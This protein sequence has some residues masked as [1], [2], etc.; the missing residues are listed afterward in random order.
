MKLHT[1]RYRDT[2]E[3]IVKPYQGKQMSQSS[4]WNAA[5]DGKNINMMKQ[6]LWSSDANKINQA[7]WP[8]PQGMEATIDKLPLGYSLILPGSSGMADSQKEKGNTYVKKKTCC[9][10]KSKWKTP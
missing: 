5:I 7:Y 3:M 9:S 1:T 8:K 2:M 4:L 6:A 10:Q